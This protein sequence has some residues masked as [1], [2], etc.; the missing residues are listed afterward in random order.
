MRRRHVL[1]SIGGLSV[2]SGAAALAGATTSFFA[3]P[4]VG[5]RFN[6][7]GSIDVH[8]GSAFG[9]AGGTTTVTA[10]SYDGTLNTDA[11]SI[12]YVD[13]SGQADRATIRSQLADRTGFAAVADT[14]SNARFN[15]GIAIPYSALSGFPTEPDALRFRFPRIVEIV[16]RS[17]GTHDLAIRFDPGG[18]TASAP[19]DTNGF[20]DSSIVAETSSA[21]D[22]Y[23]LSYDQVAHMFSFFPRGTLS[24]GAYQLDDI[25]T[26]DTDTGGANPYPPRKISSVGAHDGDNG[27][28]QPPYAFQLS[29]GGESV[30]LDLVVSVTKSMAD[31]ITGYQAAQQLSTTGGGMALLDAVYID[32]FAVSESPGV[33]SDATGQNT[34]NNFTTSAPTATE[35]ARTG[36]Q[37]GQDFDSIAY[38]FTTV[39]SHTLDL[40][41]YDDSYTISAVAVGGGGGGGGNY[42]TSGPG[43]SGG[44]GGGLAWSNSIGDAISAGATKTLSISVGRGGD[45]GTP[46]ANG[47]NGEDSTVTLDGSVLLRGGGGDGG[48]S[49]TSNTSFEPPGGS[50]GGARRDGGGRGGHGGAAAYNGAGAGGGGAGGYSGPG[51]DGQGSGQGYDPG[52]GGGGG[53]GFD[54]NSQAPDYRSSGGGVG[55]RGTGSNGRAATSGRAAEGGSGGGDATS[56]RG[57]RYGGGG[58]AS[59]DDTRTDG[60]D[61]AQ[62]AVAII[63]STEGETYPDPSFI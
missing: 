55:I 1:V 16:N 56:F 33:F 2:A 21:S 18:S 13:L 31:I 8:K 43:A 46:Y 4:D 54:L 51:G 37:G 14:T 25:P 6:V 57:G 24:T 5:F 35:L 48:Y 29:S 32:T 34:P 15:L 22:P 63:I 40:E 42:G 7:P 28:Q 61:G 52:Q 44:G 19:T 39:G 3:R 62:G 26:D 58:G 30:E 27:H 36:G 45:G 47:D 17:D 53:G 12:D 23:Q 49:N 10:D 38:A 9:G 41:Q 59:E 20:A 11:L 60:L 50:S